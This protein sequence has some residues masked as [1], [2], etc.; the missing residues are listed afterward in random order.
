MNFGAFVIGDEILVGKRQDKHLAFLIQALARRG[1]R[2]AWAEYHGD[3]PARLTAALR[4]SFASGDAVFSFGGIGATPD[5]HTRQCAAAALGV[6]LALHPEAEA[7]IRGRFGADITPQRLRMGEFPVGAAIIPNPF[8]RIPGFAIRDHWFVP[9][10]PQMAWPMAEWVLDTKY[11]PLF[12]RDRWDE[13][14]IF[15]YLPESTIAPLME[16]INAKY[17]GLKAFSLP[18]MGEG[19]SRRHIELGV[20]GAPADVEPAM[21]DLKRGIEALGGRFDERKG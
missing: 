4:R 8:N 18:S 7:E 1:L 16:E 3:D 11:R 19:G 12:D 9:G 6:D 21:G 15:V 17:P 14:S 20:R 2:L 5:D 13:G 10:F